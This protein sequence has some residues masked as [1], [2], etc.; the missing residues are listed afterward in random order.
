MSQKTVRE[1]IRDTVLSIRDDASFYYA[2]ESDFNSI[3]NKPKG[4]KVLLLPLRHDDERNDESTNRNYLVT[5]LFYEYDVVNGAE[6]DSQKILDKTDD[7]LRKFQAK[8]DLKALN[9]DEFDQNLSTDTVEISNE[10][11][12]ERIRF[13]ADCVTGWE[14]T[15]NLLVPDQLDYCTVYD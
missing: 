6:V 14:L 2:R 13:T 3:K 11:I 7:F 12:T 8:L 5:I 4:I 9:E 10:S 1:L 15:F